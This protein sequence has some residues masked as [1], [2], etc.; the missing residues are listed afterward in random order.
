[1]VNGLAEVAAEGARRCLPPV[2]HSAEDQGLES[3][4]IT[5]LRFKAHGL[6]SDRPVFPTMVPHG[7]RSLR[8]GSFLRTAIRR[9]PDCMPVAVNAAGALRAGPVLDRA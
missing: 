9:L 2:Y 7:F 8:L 3:P 4:L 5:S 6:K 1:M